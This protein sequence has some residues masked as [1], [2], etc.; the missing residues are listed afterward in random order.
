MKILNKK[1][2]DPAPGGTDFYLK[3]QSSHSLKRKTARELCLGDWRHTKR[4]MR[5]CSKIVHPDQQPRP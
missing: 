3:W 2:K 4:G 1:I 5:I